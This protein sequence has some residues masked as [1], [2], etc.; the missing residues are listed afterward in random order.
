MR[1]KT[2]PDTF[3]S[4]SGFRARRRWASAFAGLFLLCFTLS[5]TAQLPPPGVFH[6]VDFED[7]D[8]TELAI[9]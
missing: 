6:S 3:L 8:Q 5:A 4:S 9:P 1:P 7:T 2:S